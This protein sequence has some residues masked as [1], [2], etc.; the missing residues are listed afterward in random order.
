MKIWTKLLT[1][2]LCVALLC[3]LTCAALAEGASLEVH[4][5]H[6]RNSNGTRNLYDPGVA[7]AVLE[8]IPEGSDTPVATLT[9]D[10]DAQM[11]FADVPAGRYFLRVTAPVDMGF[12]KPGEGERDTTRNIMSLSLDREQ[13]S[14]VLDLTDGKK[15]TVAIG[16]TQ[17]AGVTGTVWSDLNGDGIMQEDEPGQA[18]VTISLLGVN[19]GLLY[20]LVTDETGVYYIG[21]VKP[22]NYKM[23]ITLPE[24]SMFTKY[25]KTGGV[26]RSVFTAEGKSSDHRSFKLEAGDLLENYH[27][28]VVGDGAIHVQCFLD[29]NYN[30][31]LDEGEEPFAG[32]KV[33]VVKS[34][35]NNV[36]TVTSGEDGLAVASALR[37]GE[38][39]LTAVIPEGYAFT[40]AADGGNL[41]ANTTGRRKDTV[42]NISVSTGG[43][44]TVQLGAVVPASITGTAYLDDDFSGTMGAKEATVSGLLVTL[45][46]ESGKE[47][48][49][50]RTNA[51]G[52][53][54]FEDLV[55]GVYT[56]SLKAKN[57]YA[58][59]K[60]GEGN[61]FI[62]QGEGMGATEPFEVIMGANLTGMDIGQIRPGTVQGSVFADANDN[63]LWDGAEAGFAGTQV[64]LMS[65]EGAAFTATIGED[66][67]FCFD[68]VMPGRYYLQYQ[69][70][71]RGV[72]AAV[73]EGGNTI[74]EQCGQWFD[75][76][77]GDQVDAPLCGGLLLGEISGTAF[78]DHNANGKQDAGEE[79]L[80]GVTLTLEPARS[81]LQTMTVTTGADGAFALNDLHPDT[82][83]LTVKQ[84]EGYVT[85]R[86]DAL[87][88]AEAEQEQSVALPLAMGDTW[89]EVS[90]GGVQPGAIAGKAWLDE[91]FDGLYTEGESAPA[92]ATVT[93]VDESTGEA[94][95]EID[96]EADGSF[97]AENLLPGSYTL[98]HGP[99]IEGK[100]GD[101]TFVYEN[102]EMVMKNVTLAENETRTDL[103]LGVICHTSIGG[104]A[105]VDMG[106]QVEPMPGAQVS[107]LDETDA[108]IAAA[109]TDESGAYAFTGLM[110]GRYSLTVEL[111][112][113]RV[114]VEPQDQR[115]TE[116]GLISVMTQCSGRS[117]RSDA[118]DLRMSRDMT[119]MD[120]GAV[121][122][123]ALGDLCWLDENANGLQDSGE[124]GIPNM[125]VQLLRDGAPVAETITDQ[126]GF[127]RFTDVYP[128]T[129]TLRAVAPAQVKPTTQRTDIRLLAS[130]LGEDGVSVPVQVVSGQANRNADL[131]FVLVESG[132]YPEGY[133]MGAAQVWTVGE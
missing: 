65:Q 11:L 113:G 6:D 84:P 92:N 76:A 8:L 24:G 74:A 45:M 71:Q 1:V 116:G 90:L 97:V 117:A 5:Y 33:D 105:W 103:L 42:G 69:F 110:P 32:V 120:I 75:F 48:A 43:T 37:G 106:G 55:P 81:D 132:V 35:G 98:R 7:G 77:T 40:C 68:A 44:T 96:I 131:G 4:V 59:T 119:A 9:T 14:P 78:A 46:D 10:E 39:S 49:T 19:N 95:A 107:L 2:L 54:T 108:V 67:S 3:S 93:V 56:M 70:P 34:N 31:L 28:G 52:V 66:G 133:G 102:G 64:S 83:T 118:I 61:C 82:Y 86:V 100:A 126:Y 80:A 22:G 62:N 91:N 38:F 129:Y 124:G 73:A 16:L 57:G 85:S 111:P 130:V 125:T 72:A 17:L 112:E 99:A 41:F 63:G 123:G 122:P 53:Y 23:T 104:N 30:G 26:N 29:A 47:I 127:Y 25:S 13:D 94:V 36:A 121:L 58:F 12:S 51:K 60:L 114:V 27:I 89:T 109:V 50:A 88:L 115:L 15:T 101:S 20:E 79:P 21:Q 128:A 18:G 87:P